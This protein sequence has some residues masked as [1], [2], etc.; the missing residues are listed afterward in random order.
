M[1][2]LYA[3][4]S[5]FFKNSVKAA[6]LAPEAINQ[7]KFRFELT[8]DHTVKAIIGILRAYLKIDL[9]IVKCHYK[10]STEK[11]ILLWE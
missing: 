11:E 7:Q 10:L 8:D 9:G 2:N 6:L 1:S 4:A 3:G 5:E